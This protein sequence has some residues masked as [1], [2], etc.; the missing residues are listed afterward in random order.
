MKVNGDTNITR[1]QFVQSN[2]IF[3]YSEDV[4]TQIY[5]CNSIGRVLHWY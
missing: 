4:N 3:A 2:E 5:R 1:V